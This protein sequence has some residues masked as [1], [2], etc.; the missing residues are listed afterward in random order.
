MNNHLCPFRGATK[1]HIL[2]RKE[3]TGD[4]YSIYEDAMA[5]LQSKLNT[6]LI[7][8]AR[9]RDGRLELPVD[10]LREALVNAIVHRD[11]RSTANVQNYIFHDRVE[12]VTPGG[13]P[14]GMRKGESMKCEV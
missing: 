2:D 3:F 11:Y 10:A 8:H 6:A 9:G 14:S 5:Y 4:L 13:L 12:I 7:P 1:T